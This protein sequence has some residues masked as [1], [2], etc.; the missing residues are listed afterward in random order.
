MDCTELKERKFDG[1]DQILVSDFLVVLV[2]ECDTLKISE[3]QAL[4]ALPQFLKGRKESQ[5]HEITNSA[6]SGGV[7]SW[8][9][10][11]QYLL[12]TYPISAAI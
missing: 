2:E 1:T 12:R 7:S 11:E 5:Y 6:E 10:T 3:G 9:E 8:P 4:I